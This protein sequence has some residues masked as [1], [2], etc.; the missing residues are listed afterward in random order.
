M[1]NTVP[2]YLHVM[3]AVIRG[4][5]G[6][7]LLAQRPLDK[8][9][10]G[11]WEFPG[12]KL[13]AGE[14]PLQALARELDEE[15]G[16]IPEQAVPLIKVRHTYPKRAVLLDVWEVTAFS[17]KPHGKEGQPVAWFEAE[18]M[19]E[20]EFPPANYPIVVAATL[21]DY[22]LI[23]PEPGQPDNFL[24]SLAVSLDAGIRLV[25]FR[26]KSLSD[27]AYLALAREAI[28]LVHAAGGKLILNS[29]PVMLD[30]AD[31]LHLTSRQL[32]YWCDEGLQTQGKLLS[33][34]C[35]NLAEL[36]R[37]ADIRV[38]FAFLAPVLPTASH[39]GAVALGWERFGE[40]VDKTNLPVYALGGMQTLQLAEAR[41]LGA[42]GVAG[43]SAFWGW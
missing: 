17:G 16:I 37:A 4:G 10:G 40:W 30:E 36:E 41:A 29:P 1:L 34:S 31:G 5:D 13:E 14:T 3:A 38:D 35:H 20:L 39:P 27:K 25:Q 42:R 28:A 12:G 22:C 8:H 2:E 32:Q 21:P 33:A 11:K 26:A 43:I 18:D 7:I 6:R 24:R 23:T 9:Q 15:L 19:R